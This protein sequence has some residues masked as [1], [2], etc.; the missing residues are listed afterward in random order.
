MRPNLTPGFRNVSPSIEQSG[1]LGSH[2]LETVPPLDSGFPSAIEPPT[3]FEGG[4]EEEGSPG[5]L[6]LIE[7]LD[8]VEAEEEIINQAWGVGQE[9]GRELAVGLVNEE[10]IRDVWN[11]QGLGSPWTVRV[12]SKLIRIH[13]PVLVFLSETKSRKRKCDILKERHNLFSISV[14]SKGKGGGLML[15]WQKEVN[16]T[17]HSFSSSRIDAV[18]CVQD[19]TNGWRFTGIYRQPMQHVEWKPGTCSGSSA[20]SPQGLGLC[21]GL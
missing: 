21:W 5:V 3:G 14:D 10:L 4:V 9:T 20:K 15:L 2:I 12:L 16:L 8:G 7:Q 13:N 18:V 11:C 6:C 17:M 19:G 1:S